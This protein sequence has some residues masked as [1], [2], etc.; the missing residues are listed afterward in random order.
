MPYKLFA[1]I[2]E[3]GNDVFSHPVKNTGFGLLWMV[4]HLENVFYV[5]V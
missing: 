4:F 2:R 1:P 5:D 3:V